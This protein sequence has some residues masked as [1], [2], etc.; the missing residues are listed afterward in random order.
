VRFSRGADTLTASLG[1]P[2]AVKVSQ[3]ICANAAVHV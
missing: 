2:A 3:V 1:K